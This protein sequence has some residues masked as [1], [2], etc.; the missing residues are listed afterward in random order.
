MESNMKKIRQ[1]SAMFLVVLMVL[2]TSIAVFASTVTFNDVTIQNGQYM[3]FAK[4]SYE[5]YQIP[6][7]TSV[8]HNITFTAPATSAVKSGYCKLNSSNNYNYINCLSGQNSKYMYGDF[9]IRT[10]GQ[11]KMFIFN[12]SANTMT[13]STFSFTF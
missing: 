3:R 11:Y 7:N 8:N 9:T 4:H 6:G 13:V 10:A 2:M 5:F 12:G 1:L